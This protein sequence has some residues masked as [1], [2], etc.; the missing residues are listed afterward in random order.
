VGVFSFASRLVGMARDRIL[1]G[2]FGAGD[3]LDAYYAAFK[4]PD[5]IFNLLVVGALSAGFIPVF[6]A[7]WRRAPGGK[8][9]W[10][11]ANG[12]LNLLFILMAVSLV[13]LAFFSEPLAV[14][15]AP[16]FSES[17]RELVASLTRIMLLA[18]LGL[19]VSMIFGS[20]LQGRRR[21]VL[22]ALA[23]VLY[24]IGII[25]GALVLVPRWG[26]SGLAWGVVIGSILHALVQWVG[27]RRMGYRYH[28]E[29]GWNLA[30]VREALRLTGPRLFGL[31]VSQIGTVVML[32]LASRL[33]AGSV[34]LFMF[35]SNIQYLPVGL[36]GVS[37]AVAAFPL[38]SE[39]ATE[40][41]TGRF[42]ASFSAAARQILFLIIPFT[43]AFVLLRAQIVRVAV[44]AGKFG[45][46][47]T[48]ATADAV[49]IFALSFASQCLVYL[50]ARAFFALKDT[51]TP[52]AAGAASLMVVLFAGLYLSE[53]FGVAGLAAAFSLASIAQLM[54]L[55]LPLRARL[56]SLDEMRML[57][58]LYLLT[59]AGLAGG[60][61]MQLLKPLTVRF[62]PLETF[63]NVLL[64]GTVA[65]LGGW[66]VYAA[67]A[68]VLKNEEIHAFAGAL[69]QRFFRS[70]HP[71]E[72]LPP[73]GPTVS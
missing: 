40:G 36:V 10:R 69:R 2:L 17:K 70:T 42:V 62:F 45:W 20:V 6:T 39:Q 31:A 28:W 9:A 50:L 55:W 15:V 22:F 30:D 33:Q 44:G 35:A 71:T 73:E 24:N 56:G 37:Y 12:M 59:S 11:F 23:P 3:V 61:M 18:Q 60:L 1:A 4:V 47:E 14:I 68:W 51:L 49:A 7:A 46:E 72:A 41:K 29:C 8:E 43:L 19:T 57:R 38:L 67:L 48:I 63:W 32:V 64:Q 58:S 53:R 21:F 5:L 13:V 65:G 54:F 34:T 25:A 52:L 16:G 26:P 27:A 66:T